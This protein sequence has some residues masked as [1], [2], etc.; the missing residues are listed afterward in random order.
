[1]A[2]MFYTLE[3]V[4]QKLGKSS[5]DVK[6]MARR[7]EIQEFRDR[8]KLMFK[9]DQIDM[10]AGGEDESGEIPLALEDSRLGGSGL[11]LQDSGLALADSREASSLGSFDTDHGEAGEKPTRSGDK[12]AARTQAA[13]SDDELSL[14]AVGSGSGLLDL[15]RESDDTSLGAE[16]LE[17]V[18]SSDE[19]VEIPANAS[20]LFEAAGVESP[21]NALAGGG[22]MAMVPMAMEAYDGSWSGLGVGLM[23]G[24]LVA[25]ICMGVI[26]FVGLGGSTAG[27][28]R[29]FADNLMIWGGGLLGVTLV[30]GAVGF[31]I[32]KATE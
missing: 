18:Y 15:T 8:E 4:A 14:E 23:I 5:D 12:A 21:G 30:C 10:L 13:P 7:G 1:M 32:G 19:N 17:E 3:E 26:I 25:L 16:L 24:A 2:K 29:M 31:F 28:A 20:G 22:G 11:D 27:L 6:E 9:V